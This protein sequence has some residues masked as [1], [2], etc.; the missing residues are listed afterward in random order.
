MILVN[1]PLKHGRSFGSATQHFWMRSVI[2]V[3]ASAGMTVRS[4]RWPL[5]THTE[6]KASLATERNVIIYNYFI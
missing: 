1:L 3:G 4:G 2:S 5:Y 6:I